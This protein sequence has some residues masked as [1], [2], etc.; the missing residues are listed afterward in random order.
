MQY[1]Y[2]GE[3][4]RERELNNIFFFCWVISFIV[5]KTVAKGVRMTEKKE[6]RERERERNIN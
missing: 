1:R 6:E 4:K 3:R 5:L 2:E